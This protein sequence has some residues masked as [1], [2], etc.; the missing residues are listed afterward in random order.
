[1][2]GKSSSTINL[3]ILGLFGAYVALP[4]LPQGDEVRRN[5]YRS[6]EECVA[7][8]SDAECETTSLQWQRRLGL[9][10]PDL[11]RRRKRSS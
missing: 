9:P 3:V 2:S 6:R 1:V 4:F 5:T 7:D 11:P 10:G 8:Y